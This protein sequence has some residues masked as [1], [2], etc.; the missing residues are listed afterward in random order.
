MRCVFA[1]TLLGLAVVSPLL[2]FKQ[3]I[4]KKSSPSATKQKPAR[5][6]KTK[7][8]ASSRRGRRSRHVTLA[9]S[10]QTHPDPERY[11]QIQQALATRGYFKG[12]ANG[13]WGDD[14][15]DALR[16]F[17]SDQKLADNDGKITALSLNA[18]GL[19]AKHDSSNLSPTAVA[20]SIPAAETPPSPNQEPSPENASPAASESSA[21][22]K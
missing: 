12:D 15:I 2:G 3:P 8:H 4:Q 19:G 20:G 10:Y 11:R 18:L 17:E 7:S 16:R 6:S 22:P 21:P 14:S 9:P 5:S 13:V 1:L